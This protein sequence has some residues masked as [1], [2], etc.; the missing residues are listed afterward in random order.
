[1]TRF[2]TTTALVLAMATPALANDMLRERVENKLNTSSEDVDV[3]ALTDEQ[4]R[5]LFAGLSSDNSATERNALIESIVAD[6]QYR[7]DDTV[8]GDYGNFGADS[9]LR[10]VVAEMLAN[11]PVDVDVSELSDAQISAL[12]VELTSGDGSDAT[13]IEAIVG[14]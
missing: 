2:L 5:A 7:M 13:S 3:S 8:M 6:P 10:S 1:M 4:V 12:Y 14:Q 11:E 9:D